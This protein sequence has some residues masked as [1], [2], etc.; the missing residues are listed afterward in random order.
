[1]AY[2]DH[3]ISGTMARKWLHCLAVVMLIGLGSAAQQDSTVNIGRSTRADKKAIMK[4]TLDGKLDFSR[5]LIDAK[6]FIPVPIIITEPALGSFGALLAPMFL[7]PKKLPPGHKGYVP[8]DITAGLAMYTVNGSWMGGAGRIGSIPKAGIKYRA[9]LAYADINISFYRQ[10]ENIREKE[11]KFNIEAIPVFLSVSK[12]IPKTDLYLGVQYLFSKNTLSPRTN[13]DLPESI[14][15][16]QFKSNIASLG[17]FLDWD[18]RDNFFTANKGARL[19]LLYTMNDNWTGSDFTYQRLTGFLNWFIPIR[20][21]WISGLRIESANA[22][23][24][25]PFYALPSL[26]MRGV[27][28]VRYQGN[29]TVLVETEQRWDLNSRWSLVAFGGVGKA[30][31]SYQDFSDADL[32]YNLGTGFRY[33]LARA[34]GIRA[35]IDVA[36]GPGSA[37][38]YITFGHNWNR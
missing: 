2:P 31:P 9:A 10:L 23:G 38:W 35:G 4:D 3:F 18:R 15:P 19:N 36:M 25:P 14:D 34:F 20:R 7:T 8:P 24:N 5:F 37:G 29:N 33:L 12:S 11:F 1:M 32:A 13:L 26:T 22:F 17:L 16:Q 30:V 27:P 6:G 28:A 21:N